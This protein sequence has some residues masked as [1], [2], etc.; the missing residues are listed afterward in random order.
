MA[1]VPLAVWP[2]ARISGATSVHAIFVTVS[3]Y[4]RRY[5]RF[6]IE[7]Q[8]TVAMPEERVSDSMTGA[9]TPEFAVTTTMKEL[10]ALRF[11]EPSS[12][13]IVTNVLVLGAWAW[14]GVQVI[15]P[16]AETPALV[17]GPAAAVTDKV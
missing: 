11:G 1:F 5:V 15:T 14:V 3:V 9:G 8:V 6:V 12:V 2:V 17:T 16:L 4:W 7:L 10:V 13:T